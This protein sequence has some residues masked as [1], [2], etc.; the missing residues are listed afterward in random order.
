LRTGTVRGLRVSAQKLV[1]QDNGEQRR[2]DFKLTVV[3]NETQLPES[4]HKE[5]DSRAGRS[6]HLCQSLLTSRMTELD[7]LIPMG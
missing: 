7:A 1:V 2:V 5:I 3:A 4:V 6:H